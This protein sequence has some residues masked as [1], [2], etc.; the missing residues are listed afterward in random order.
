[1]TFNKLLLIAATVLL[2][3][4]GCAGAEWFIHGHKNLPLALA[5][6]AGA[7]YVAAQSWPWLTRTRSTQ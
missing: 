7:C 2:A 5:G 6:F 3:L 1:M 4:L